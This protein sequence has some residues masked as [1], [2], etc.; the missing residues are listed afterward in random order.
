MFKRLIRYI[1]EEVMEPGELVLNL[2]VVPLFI[3]ALII[4]YFALKD[5][6]ETQ[7]ANEPA[8]PQPYCQIPDPDEGFYRPN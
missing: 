7:K 3:I 1:T 8:K 5:Y 6:T 4:G 2:I